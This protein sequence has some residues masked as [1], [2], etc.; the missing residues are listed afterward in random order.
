MWFQEISKEKIP[1][2]YG[3]ID[4]MLI[5]IQ[6]PHDKKVIASGFHSQNEYCTMKKSLVSTYRQHVTIREDF[7]HKCEKSCSN[8]R[9]FGL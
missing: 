1:N 8:I 7:K 5:W 3:V 2:C 4:G 9:F 6:K